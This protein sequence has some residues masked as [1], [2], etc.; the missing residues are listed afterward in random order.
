MP[1]VFLSYDRSEAR[2]A[3]GESIRDFYSWLAGLGIEIVRSSEEEPIEKQEKRL[4]REILNASAVIVVCG[5]SLEDDRT[6]VGSNYEQHAVR[7]LAFDK[8]IPV[9]LGEHPRIDAIASN[10]FNKPALNVRSE[11]DEILAQLKTLG[12]EVRRIAIAAALAPDEPTEEDQ[13]GMTPYRDAVVKFLAS[14]RTKPP[15]TMAI[16]GEWGTGKSSFLLSVENQLEKEGFICVRFNAWRHDKEES[17]WAAFALACLRQIRRRVGLVGQL[18]A[19]LSLRL[20]RYRWED[21]GWVP[22]AKL[23]CFLLATT[24]C[25]VVGSLIALVPIV[26]QAFFETQLGLKATIPVVKESAPVASFLAG[27]AII[28]GGLKRLKN[29]FTEEFSKR[30]AGPDYAERV[31][32]IEQFHEDFGRIIRAY[33]PSKRA[34]VFVD[35]LDRCSAPKA[36]EL[37][38]AL[39]LMMSDHPNLIFIV[40]MDREKIAAGLAAKYKDVVPF[41]TLTDDKQSTTIA[42]VDYGHK[43]MQ[44]FVQVSLRLPRPD[45]KRALQMFGVKG[46]QH[47]DSSKRLEEENISRRNEPQHTTSSTTSAPSNSKPLFKRVAV[48]ELVAESDAD[49]LETVL[50]IVV[51]MLH[52]NPRRI[53]QFV[54]QFR[55]QSLVGFGIGLF[56]DSDDRPA[57]LTPLLLAKLLALQMEFPQLARDLSANPQ[58]LW[59]VESKVTNRGDI[60]QSELSELW[61]SIP[62]VASLLAIPESDSFRNRDLL[63][64]LDIMPSVPASVP[65][66]DIQLSPQQ[67][68]PAERARGNQRSE[69]RSVSD[70]PKRYMS[71][72]RAGL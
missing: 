46:P 6:G 22:V 25:V 14:A 34:F 10:L 67:S 23:L 43:F 71:D 54:N 47:I 72:T 60:S 40:A 27:V 13:L 12:I 33:L 11:R 65:A 18:R 61:G 38:Q 52:R 28:S 3:S 45:A 48:T 7:E 1:Y 68:A 58:L 17:V 16:E 50:P 70:E 36:A 20:L 37:M 66:E 30:F 9:K 32:F 59:Q 8:I 4:A 2:G 19:S 55:L 57:S 21:S 53:K 15:L 51:D 69:A 44:K 31:D 26:R 64:V 29:P 62:A 56:R 35:D 24:V 63:A 39:N 49:V 41:I 42:A 5:P